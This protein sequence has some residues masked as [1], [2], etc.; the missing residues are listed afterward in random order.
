MMD[1][2]LLALL[3]IRVLLHDPLN[4]SFLLRTLGPEF[5]EKHRDVARN[6]L[7]IVLS[8]TSLARVGLGQKFEGVVD[9]ADRIASAFDRW[10][11]KSTRWP[12][13]TYV[14]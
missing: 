3:K 8:G 7:S 12:S 10:I 11:L 14:Y 6:F 9:E 13:K 2:G 1:Y 4:K 5:S